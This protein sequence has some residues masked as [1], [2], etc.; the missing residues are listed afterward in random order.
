M[1]SELLKRMEIWRSLQIQI[2]F[3]DH[4]EKQNE[5]MMLSKDVFSL[6][7]GRMHCVESYILLQSIWGVP[8]AC[9][10]SS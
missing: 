7:K 5:N 2:S 10:G 8:L 3:V 1:A 6:A 9:L 4:C